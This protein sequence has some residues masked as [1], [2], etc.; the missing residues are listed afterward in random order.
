MKY[1]E[2]AKKLHKLG[3]EEIPVEVVGLIENG[4]TQIV[5]VLSPYLIG[6]IRT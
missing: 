2:V 4:T 5:G 1:Q 3:C 6:E